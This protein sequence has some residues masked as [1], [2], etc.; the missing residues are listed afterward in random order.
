MCFLGEMGRPHEKCGLV[1]G[2]K[3]FLVMCHHHMRPI[4]IHMCFGSL[5][6]KSVAIDV[7]FLQLPYI[8][9][10]DLRPSLKQ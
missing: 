4:T 8:L 9:D 3:A 5:D 10:G 1:V 6:L 7:L 2:K